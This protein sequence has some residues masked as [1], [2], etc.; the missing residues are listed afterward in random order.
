MAGTK[1]N[2]VDDR[3]VTHRPPSEPEG[4]ILPFRRRGALFGRKRPPAPPLS[5]LAQYERRPDE[6]DDYRHRMLMNGLALMA[7]VALVAAG[8]WIADVMAH[9][10][11][12]QDCVLSGRPGC[13]P[14]EVPVRAR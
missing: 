2:T 5:D 6:P 8:I 12:N 7:T 3:T 1:C 14:V 13:T 11:K 4:R 9:M 10:R